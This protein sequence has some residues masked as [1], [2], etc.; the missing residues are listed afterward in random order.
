MSIKL[1]QQVNMGGCDCKIG[2]D[3]LASILQDYAVRAQSTVGT[4]KLLVAND[5]FDDAAVYQMN[6]THAVL[7]SVDFFTSHR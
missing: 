4:Q 7:A 2:S 3:I 1:T 5:R 6:E